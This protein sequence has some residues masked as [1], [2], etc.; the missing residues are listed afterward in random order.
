[1]YTL[2][3]GSSSFVRFTSRYMK[4]NLNLIIRGLFF[5]TFAI[6]IVAVG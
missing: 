5:A 3:L 4:V 2:K 1:M 6:K